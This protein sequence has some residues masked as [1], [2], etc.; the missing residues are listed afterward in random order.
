M[1]NDR[2]AEITALMESVDD[3][4]AS[5]PESPD[6]EAAPKHTLLESWREVLKSIEA[7]Q[8]QK[9]TMPIAARIIANYPQIT[10][11]DC[12]VY[13]IQYHERL[14][15]MREILLAEIATDDQCIGRVDD[16][17]EG[18]HHHYLNL[19]AMW[20]RQMH[21]WETE[22]DCTDEDAHIS[23]A[24]IAD[25]G[26]FILGQ[27]GMVGHLEAIGFQ[28]SDEDAEAVMAAVLGE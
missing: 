6:T 28:F 7:A 13:H 11:Q 24:T 14:K 18:N 17:V 15:A 4:F 8:A 23:F 20:Q 2:A 19:L 16:D 26:Q 1:S 22:W 12:A 3:I 10:M 9:I 5:A 27:N 21:L 25:C